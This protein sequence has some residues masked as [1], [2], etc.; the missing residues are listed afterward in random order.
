[1]RPDCGGWSGNAGEPVTPDVLIVDALGVAAIGGILWYLRPLRKSRPVQRAEDAMQSALIIVKGGF[2][3]DTIVLERGVPTRL[4]FRREEAAPCSERVVLPAFGQSAT[5]PQGEEVS[6]EFL[7]ISR[8]EFRFTCHMG[9]MKGC[10]VV[11]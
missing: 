5:L 2:S 7:P 10:I 6:V 11:Q 9:V 1:M 4:V 8:G 3:P